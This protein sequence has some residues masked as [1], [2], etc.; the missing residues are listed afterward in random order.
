MTTPEQTKS[1]LSLVT[2]VGDAIHDL[3]SVP[4]GHLY[5]RL[6]GHLTLSQYQSIIDLL[7]RAELVK[8]DGMHLLTWIGPKKN[9]ESAKYFN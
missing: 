7:K 2:A 3:G 6:M 4:S 8:E 5:A 1:A 9:D